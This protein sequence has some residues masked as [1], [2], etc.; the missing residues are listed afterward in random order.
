MI[1]Y[2]LAIAGGYLIGNSMNE[3]PQFDEGGL[4]KKQQSEAFMDAYRKQKHP[5]YDVY[6]YKDGKWSKY[7]G[8]EKS[9]AINEAL[10]LY[11]KYEKE[12]VYVIDVDSQE[13][14]WENGNQFGKGGITTMDD[15]IKNM[16]DDEEGS[17]KRKSPK[18][19]DSSKFSPDLIK[20]LKDMGYSEEEIKKI[21]VI[22]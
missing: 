12:K 6:Y 10:K 22:S 8:L 3:T 15:Y 11:N 2:L 13:K 17:R 4:T 20:K 21:K 19:S 5:L 9:D 7:M 1:P 16:T 14:I 18:K